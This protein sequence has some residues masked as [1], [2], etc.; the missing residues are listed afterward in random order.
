MRP[1]LLLPVHGEMRHMQEQARLGRACGIPAAIVQKNGDI[2]RLAPDRLGKLAEVHAGRLVLDGDVIVP[3]DGEAITM[4]R[5]MARDG[6]AIVVVDRKGK[7]QV[8]GIGMPLDE[9]Y[10]AFVSEAEQD[11]ERALARLGKSERAD[12]EVVIEAA[13]LATRRAA[14]RWSGKRV[15]VKVMLAET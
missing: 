10:E 15:Q 14:K 8:C 11:V 9:D 3:A 13:R 2:V 4:R 12:R 7:A 5:R 6:L 1:D